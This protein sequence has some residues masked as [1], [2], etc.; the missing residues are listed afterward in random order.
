MKAPRRNSF[1]TFFSYFSHVYIKVVIIRHLAPSIRRVLAAARRRTYVERWRKQ[2]TFDSLIGLVY[3][4]GVNKAFEVL[5]KVSW[6]GPG[7]WNSR[8]PT[9]TTDYLDRW[10][11][12]SFFPCPVRAFFEMK[13]NSLR[14][15]ASADRINFQ[16]LSLVDIYLNYGNTEGSGVLV[17]FFVRPTNRDFFCTNFLNEKVACLCSISYRTLSGINTERRWKKSKA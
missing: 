13:L 10:L 12:S 15:E 2:T 1:V 16:P 5:R 9:A 14:D 3:L 6:A 7:Q 17:E 11:G 4:A 8:V